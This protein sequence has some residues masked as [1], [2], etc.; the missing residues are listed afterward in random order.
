MSSKTADVCFF[1]CIGLSI[2]LL[3]AGSFDTRWAYVCAG[4]ATATLIYRVGTTDRPSP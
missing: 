3:V 2:A 1:V 4:L